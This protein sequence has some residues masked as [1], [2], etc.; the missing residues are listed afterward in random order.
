[1]WLELLTSLPRRSF[2]ASWTIAGISGQDGY[3][4]VAFYVGVGDSD[5]HLYMGGF[6]PPY[7]LSRP[8]LWFFW[9]NHVICGFAQGACALYALATVEP[10]ALMLLYF[11]SSQNP[12][13]NMN[14]TLWETSTRE[15]KNRPKDTGIFEVWA[16]SGMVILK[17]FCWGSRWSFFA[18]LI[19]ASLG[20]LKSTVKWCISY[21]HWF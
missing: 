7:Y 16:S 18:R 6:Y 4:H 1:M 10:L 13:I 20:T 9:K 3:S 17:G 2:S 12:G 8:A 19:N 14:K 21:Y 11:V 5:I 15:F